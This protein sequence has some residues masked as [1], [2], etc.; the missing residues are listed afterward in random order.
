MPQGRLSSCLHTSESRGGAKS[1]STYV[2]WSARV[3]ARLRRS[4]DGKD[5]DHAEAY[6]RKVWVG[7]TGGF[8][9]YYLRSLGC[10]CSRAQS[11]Y[12]ILNCYSKM[13]LAIVRAYVL[14]SEFGMKDMEV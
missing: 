11:P 6:R 1:Y 9:S 7:L 12:R 14:D 13:H 3:I 8:G 5:K 10:R 2:A 4:P